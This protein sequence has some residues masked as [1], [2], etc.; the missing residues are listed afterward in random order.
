[1]K[2]STS[3][4]TIKNSK[5][6]PASTVPIQAAFKLFCLNN[7][8]TITKNATQSNLQTL[9]S[10]KSLYPP[11]QEKQQQLNTVHSV[12]TID[13]NGKSS[14]LHKVFSIE[15]FYQMPSNLCDTQKSSN[16]NNPLMTPSTQL[17][18]CIS[19]DRGLLLQTTPS[20]SM[21]GAGGNCINLNFNNKN[22]NNLKFSHLHLQSN[23][24]QP[25]LIDQPLDKKSNPLFQ[26]FQ[27]NNIESLMQNQKIHSSN[28]PNLLIN[29]GANDQQ[30]LQ[31]QMNVPLL[32]QNIQAVQ[33]PQIQPQSA[34]NISVKSLFN[35]DVR[36]ENDIYLNVILV[37]TF[38]SVYRQLDPL[39]KGYIKLKDLSEAVKG[40][41]GDGKRNALIKFFVSFVNQTNKQYISKVSFLTNSV[42]A[43]LHNKYDLNLFVQQDKYEVTYY[44]RNIQIK[45]SQSTTSGGSRTEKYPSSSQSSHQA[46]TSSN[47]NQQSNNNN[48]NTNHISIN[49]QPTKQLNI[50]QYKPEP[51]QQQQQI[52]VNQLFQQQQQTYQNLQSQ[53]QENENILNQQPQ[54]QQQQQQQQ[55][56]QQQQ[57]QINYQQSLLEKLVANQH[58]PEQLSQQLSDQ[59]LKELK[60]QLELWHQQ[61][62]AQQQL[63][64]S[65]DQQDSYNFRQN[66]TGNAN[67]S[68]NQ[69]NNHALRDNQKSLQDD[70]NMLYYKYFSGQVSKSNQLSKQNELYIQHLLAQSQAYQQQKKIISSI[71]S[72]SNQSNKE[73]ITAGMTSQIFPNQKS[74]HVNL[75]GKDGNSV[76]RNEKSNGRNNNSHNNF[77]NNKNFTSTNSNFSIAAKQLKNKQGNLQNHPLRSSQ[78]RSLKQSQL[79]STSEL[80][81]HSTFDS[82]KGVV[83]RGRK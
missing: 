22:L 17:P 30:Q 76:S 40:V 83:N 28:Q 64:S 69:Q 53:Q 15:N 52:N 44:D 58:H 60:Y 72:P 38:K 71:I 21:G 11:K 57:N 42:S 56:L 2:I 5:N 35:G 82:L 10:Q 13:G 8:N 31:N 79:N 36:G 77:V 81:P 66:N 59:Q 25:H 19:S 4:Q 74:S 33:I 50:K 39:K 62:E 70:I 16:Y 29:T 18:R 55:Q 54:Q 73:N 80:A 26:T 27:Q 48:N 67:V 32:M 43:C 41:E 78:S 23:Q 65:L 49:Q 24:S 7:Q 6:T 75:L 37:D 45:Q 61:Y 51:K 12:A 9:N 68:Q 47:N 14:N 34:K 3:E 1:M 20:V 63:Q 46:S